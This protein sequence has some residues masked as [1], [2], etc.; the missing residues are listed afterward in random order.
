MDYTAV[1]QTTH[2]AACMEQMALPGSILLTQAALSLAEGYV[3]VTSLGP[4]PVKGL[5]VPVAVF[6][7]VGASGVRRR[8][9]ATATR[10]LS[11]F[12]GRGAGLA[13]LNHRTAR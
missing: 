10:G 4:V 2:L 5:D 9:Q 8:L 11:T 12:V 13:A 3:R 6:E 1:G 7:L